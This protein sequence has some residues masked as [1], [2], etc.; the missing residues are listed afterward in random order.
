MAYRLIVTGQFKKDVKR[1]KKRGLPLDEL[2]NA[3][4]L[5]LES[6]KLPEKYMTHKLSGSKNG[7]LECYIRPD[8][9]LVWKQDDQELV[10]LL[11]STGTHSDLF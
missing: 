9:L 8:W 2:W 1:C 5:L 6:G 11:A 4:R 10:I 3:I 7:L